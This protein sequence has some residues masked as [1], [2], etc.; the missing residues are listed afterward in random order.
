MS[1]A[2]PDGCTTS[3]PIA[4]QRTHVHGCRRHPRGH[5]FV[6]VIEAALGEC[7]VLLVLIG[8]RWL[9][10]T[11]KTGTVIDIYLTQEESGNGNGF[12]ADNF[13]LVIAA[14]CAS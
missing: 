4:G 11:G 5:D 7:D 14:D 8:N 12:Y 9:T 2:T 10:G 3:W 6:E 13:S 1:Q